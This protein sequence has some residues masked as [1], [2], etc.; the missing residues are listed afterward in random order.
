MTTTAATTSLQKKINTT[1]QNKNGFSGLCLGS[2][3]PSL[4]DNNLTI[5]QTSSTTNF[6]YVTLFQI[7]ISSTI[8][9]IGNL[10]L[11]S[12]SNVFKNF[13]SFTW[14]TILS[15]LAS[16]YFVVSPIQITI[17]LSTSTVIANSP[18]YYYIFDSGNNAYVTT[19]VPSGF[20]S[21]GMISPPTGY[22]GVTELFYF[23]STVDG[24]YGIQPYNSSQQ[25]IAT[26]CGSNNTPCILGN[27]FYWTLSSSISSSSYVTVT[28]QNQ[29][30]TTDF[31]KDYISGTKGSATQIPC[32]Q[33]NSY[34]YQIVPVGS[35]NG[36]YYIYDP[37]LSVFLTTNVPSGF[38]APGTTST[39]NPGTSELFYFQQAVSSNEGAG[40]FY[41][42]TIYMITPYGT[43]LYIGASC[44]S[45]SP[46]VIS[47]NT[48]WKL[49][50]SISSTANNTGVS[51]KQANAD[52]S[53]FGYYI[54]NIQGS[55][56]QIP[57]MQTSSYNFTIIPVNY[58]SVNINMSFNVV[59]A[60]NPL[61]TSFN[62][63][64]DA[65]STSVSTFPTLTVTKNAS[66]YTVSDNTTTVTTYS[67]LPTNQI[68]Q[69]VKGSA[70]TSYQGK[71]G[72]SN[73]NYFKDK[74]NITVTSLFGDC[75]NI[76]G[77]YSVQVQDAFP[78]SYTLSLPLL[79]QNL[80]QTPTSGL[81]IVDSYFYNK[82]FY[83]QFS[84]TDKLTVSRAI[85]GDQTSFIQTI[86]SNPGPIVFTT[87]QIC[88]NKEDPFVP[89][90]K[91]VC[92]LNNLVSL[93]KVETQ[94]KICPSA[95]MG[96]FTSLLNTTIRYNQQQYITFYQQ[97][98]NPGK[99]LNNITT[100]SN[101]TQNQFQ[102]KYIQKPPPTTN[103]TEKQ[104]TAS[105]NGSAN[106][107]QG[108]FC[109][110]VHLSFPPGI[111]SFTNTTSYI[112]YYN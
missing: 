77:S 97:L 49:S 89:G 18:Q 17:N 109:G 82:A 42:D 24:T 10:I 56:T 60:G 13:P 101:N 44:S 22:P 52:Q 63:T 74:N 78:Q 95:F 79:F 67:L 96:G 87:Y 37:L 19:N 59:N 54:S 55:A 57:C 7:D 75:L 9:T 46:C 23:Q 99:Y 84:K 58:K 73:I 98:A 103:K 50:S 16:F 92:C 31:Y 39:T 110:A 1:F 68:S 62:L 105:F 20:T 28:I 4:Q 25:Y 21:P 90:K 33:S 85:Q 72:F 43:S 70:T 102:R 2:I 64:K 94:G 38:S 66:T 47:S 81:A 8:N 86:K 34:N 93:N 35:T 6:S 45:N 26:G 51:F 11:S 71:Q 27:S 100:R 108:S 107:P 14:D 12:S 3:I 83:N 111:Y 91:Y 32:M 15:E 76:P 106:D 53:F 80:G 48:Y 41:S 61:T 36:Y 112:I 69:L 29:N 30:D 104:N 88:K 65:S 40:Y 5:Q